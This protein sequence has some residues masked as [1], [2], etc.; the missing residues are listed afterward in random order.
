MQ[1]LA[2]TVRALSPKLPCNQYK[3]EIMVES[4]YF[5]NIHRVLLCSHAVPGPTED[6]TEASAS[7]KGTWVFTVW[8][9]K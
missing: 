4:V 2:A 8:E 3:K 6:S 7:V 1:S 9:K 5:T